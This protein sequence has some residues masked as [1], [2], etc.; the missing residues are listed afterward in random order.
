VGSDQLRQGRARSGN[1]GLARNRSR[2]LPRR[3]GR[4]RLIAAA[5][6][7]ELAER[8]LAAVGAGDGAQ[9][10]VTRERSLLLR[11]ARSR[12]TQATHIDDLTVELTVARDGH[13][14]TAA[15]NRTDDDALTACAGAA[16]GAADATAR[17]APAAGP[18]PGFAEPAPVRGHD[19]HSA[20]TAMLDTAPGGAALEAAFAAAA[21]AGTEAHGVWTAAET[22]TAIAATTGVAVADRLTDAFM[23][24]TAIAPT[25]RSGYAATTA[26]DAR[27][28]DGHGLAERAAAKA[29][30][31]GPDAEPARLEPDELPVVLEPLAVGEL[32]TWLG[33]LALNG[34]AFAEGRSALSGRLGT[35]IA[36]PRIN[37]S[38]SPRLRGTLPRAFDFEGVPKGPLPLIQDGVA[39][40]VVHDRHSAALAGG[41]A[42]STGHALA[43][44]GAPDGPAPTNLVLVGGGASDEAELCRRIERGIYVTRLWYTNAVRPK[45]TLLT[46]VTRDGTFLIEDGEVTRPAAELRFTDR[47]LGVLGRAQ[48]LTARPTLTS[49]GE[50]Y[51]RR[52]ATGVVCPGL[53]AE[54]LRFTG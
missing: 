36:A 40:R 34:L 45:E 52:F 3:A 13:L 15:T 31:G 6:A 4:G 42:S 7:T 28:L 2:S 51:G 54:S 53:R 21:A 39:Q 41:G 23:K 25:G 32:L 44:G 14:A 35:R 24:V 29:T 47:V 17:A 5:R 9:A 38:D 26:I 22:E 19:G 16:E 46:G 8:A 33:H 27:E 20:E 1:A 43:P 18:H 48:E 30:F 10:T 12:P 11:F 49:E 37:L 50:F